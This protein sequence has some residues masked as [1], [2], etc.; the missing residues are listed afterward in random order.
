[1][2]RVGGLI[3]V[4]LGAAFVVIAVLLRFYIAPAL[5]KAPLD[6]Y[7]ITRALAPN[8]TYLDL[9]AGLKIMHGDLEV[10]RVVKGDT[11]AGSSDVAVWEVFVGIE[12]ANDSLVS[13]STDR[14]AFDR[15]T[16]VA[17]NC[18]SENVNGDKTVRHQGIE[19]KFPFHAKKQT[20]Q[21]FDTSIRKATPMRF[22]GAEKLHGV[23]VYRYVQRIEPTKIAELDVPGSLLG[24]SEPSVTADRMY[25]NVRTVWVEPASGVIVKGQERQLST[26]QG[27][28]G[29]GKATITDAVLTSTEPTVEQ[30]TDTAADAR[31]T[32]RVLEFT[33][34][35]ALAFLGVLLFALGLWLVRRANGRASGR[36]AAKP[37]V[38]EPS[39]TETAQSSA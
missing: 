15:R 1:M 4:G 36:H 35:L 38:D 10:T 16:S 39:P 27:S 32:L 28:D 9:S 34:V 13:A 37:E 26:L 2:R 14:V 3:L 12:T 20:Y 23:P 33:G 21:Y 17:V 30:Q 24:R 19:Y 22:E 6:Q 25:S 7:T 29:N 8:A 18:C 31:R 11:N 5:A